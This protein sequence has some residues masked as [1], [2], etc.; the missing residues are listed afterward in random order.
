[1]IVAGSGLRVVVA[2][3]PVDFRK[4]HD[5]LV[6]VVENDRR[7]AGQCCA[8]ARRAGGGRRAR[9]APG[10]LD[11]HQ[12][13]RRRAAGTV[14]AHRHLPILGRRDDAIAAC[15]RSAE[16]HPSPRRVHNYAGG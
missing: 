16:L 6:A 5:G 3:R 15:A 8:A 11:V 7:L 9:D 10:A 14:R 1:M 12:P 2:T 13:H 4:G